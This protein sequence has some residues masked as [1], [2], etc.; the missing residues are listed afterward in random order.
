MQLEDSNLTGFGL[1]ITKCGKGYFFQFKAL[2]LLLLTN[3]G[4][5]DEYE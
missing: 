4:P 3:S 5:I 2:V 1:R